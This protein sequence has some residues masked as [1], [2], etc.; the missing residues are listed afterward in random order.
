MAEPQPNVLN[1]ASSMMLRLRIHLDLQL[2]HVAALRSAHQP[3]AD[4]VRVLVQRAH[5]ARML[6]VIEYL[7]AVCHPVF[8]FVVSSV[9]FALFGLSAVVAL[10]LPLRSTLKL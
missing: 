4:L 10:A 3:G 2:H 7:F 9:P 8:S 5:I 1:L 6:V